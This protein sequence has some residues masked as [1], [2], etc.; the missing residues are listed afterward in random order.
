LTAVNVEAEAWRSASDDLALI[1]R[2]LA[3][4]E[5]RRDKVLANIARYQPA[6]VQDLKDA[7]ERIVETEE[8]PLIPRFQL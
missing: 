2:M 4:L 7:G 6:L 8:A 1:E 5:Y 3:S